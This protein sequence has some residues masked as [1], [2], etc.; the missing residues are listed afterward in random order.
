MKKG[1]QKKIRFRSRLEEQIA[2]QLIELDQAWAYEGE[3]FPYII[4]KSLHTYCPDFVIDTSKGNLYIECK[5]KHR[6]GGLDKKT[7]DKMIY[8][9]DQNEGLDI[10]FIFDKKNNRIGK[11]GRSKTWEKW[12]EENNFLYAINHIPREW[13]DE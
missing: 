13:L 9:R 1:K 11:S 10:R 3:T 4:P 6:W 12:C 7:R 8:V 2:D 5:G